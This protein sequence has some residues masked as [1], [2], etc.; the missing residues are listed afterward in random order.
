MGWSSCGC[1]VVPSWGLLCVLDWGSWE[2]SSRLGTGIE[3]S[4][5]PDRLLG[6]GSGVGEKDGEEGRDEGERER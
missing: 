3:V 2:G 1:G 4:L 5:E 6:M